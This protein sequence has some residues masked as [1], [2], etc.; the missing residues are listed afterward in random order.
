M[1]RLIEVSILALL[2]SASAWADWRES[3]PKAQ[4]V[5]Q[6]EMRWLGFSV[7]EAELW[8]GQANFDA[9]RPYALRLR[10]QRNI[11]ASR[12]VT[13]SVDEMRRLGAPEARLKD[14]EGL[15]GQAFV[16]VK[17]GD[18]IIG[19]HTPGQGARFYAGT[20]L[21]LDTRDADS[22]R[23]FFA[24]WLHPETREPELRRALIGDAR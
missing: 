3:L 15:M 12:L 7:Y 17:P 20:R 13:T 22:S 11:A 4:R 23:W 10:Y 9:A 16:D 6:G 19:V 24:I 1:R 2:V 5:G 18:E 8:G 14:W 21:T